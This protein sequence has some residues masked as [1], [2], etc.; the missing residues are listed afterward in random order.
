MEE[1]IGLTQ[2]ELAL[3][4][5]RTVKLCFFLERKADWFLGGGGIPASPVQNRVQR[6]QRPLSGLSPRETPG[7]RWLPS[8][9]TTDSAPELVSA[10]HRPGGW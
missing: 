9:R 7:H 8:T 3:S 10:H 4:E 1:K 5:N 6:R 2:Q